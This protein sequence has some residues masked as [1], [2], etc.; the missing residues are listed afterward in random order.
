MHSSKRHYA[1]FVFKW[2]P[3][4]WGDIAVYRWNIFVTVSIENAST[5][6]LTDTHSSIFIGSKSMFLGL[7]SQP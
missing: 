2:F 7:T 3:K 1:S 4:C 5:I 6:A